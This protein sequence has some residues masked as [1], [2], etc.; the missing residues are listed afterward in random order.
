MIADLFPL[1]QDSTSSDGPER[2]ESAILDEISVSYVA[3]RQYGATNL[4][5]TFPSIGREL[6]IFPPPGER[7]R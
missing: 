4:S 1:L 6:T 5:A 7:A 2:S 3:C